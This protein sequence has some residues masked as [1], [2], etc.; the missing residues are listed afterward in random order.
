MILWSEHICTQ[1]PVHFSRIHLIHP[2]S[3]IVGISPPPSHRPPSCRTISFRSFVVAPVR[4]TCASSLLVDWKTRTRKKLMFYPFSWHDNPRLTALSSKESSVQPMLDD[5][6]IH[7]H[8]HLQRIRSLQH[9]LLQVCG[10]FRMMLGG[11]TGLLSYAFVA[12]NGICIIDL[13][14][15]GV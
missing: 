3:T 15:D 1:C 5:M 12:M 8:S 2:P 10:T 4:G 14:S 6:V 9:V 7:S 11:S 13:A